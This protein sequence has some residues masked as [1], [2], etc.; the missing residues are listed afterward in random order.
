MGA[1]PTRGTIPRILLVTGASEPACL[2]STVWRVRSP[3]GHP[4]SNPNYRAV[5]PAAKTPVFQTGKAG[6]APA[7]RILSVFSRSVIGNQFPYAS[8]A[9]KCADLV[10]RSMRVKTLS[11]APFPTF[12]LVAQ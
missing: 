7:Q 12:P 6:A 10:N 4:F 11:L 1:V 2:Q 3:H 5:G 8:V 9:D